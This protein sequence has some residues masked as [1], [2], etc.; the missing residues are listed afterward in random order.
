MR[1]RTRH[2]YRS[3]APYSPAGIRR[4]ESAP[5]ICDESCTHH[6]RHQIRRAAAAQHRPRIHQIHALQRR[7]ETV[8]I[9]L[10][11]HHLPS[12]RMSAPHALDREWPAASRR[13]APAPAIPEPPA[14]A[15]FRAPAV[16]C[17]FPNAPGQSTNR[18]AHR[19]PPTWCGAASYQN[20][21][22][23]MLS[24]WVLTHS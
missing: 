17:G 13:P 11:P 20:L 18:A 7:R 24:D 9:T 1:E 3:A 12:V 4:R 10:A 8:R 14:T 19:S 21:F 16:D 2:R 5:D 6:P 15:L 22:P 23:P